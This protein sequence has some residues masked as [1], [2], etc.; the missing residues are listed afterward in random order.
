[1]MKDVAE[2]A[3]KANMQRFLS[4]AVYNDE[5]QQ[6]MHVDINGWLSAMSDRVK[7]EVKKVINKHL[8]AVREAVT[9]ADSLFT[10]REPN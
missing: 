10:C 2:M 3:G 8:P 7:A 5:T 1:M 9:S 6:W 4:F